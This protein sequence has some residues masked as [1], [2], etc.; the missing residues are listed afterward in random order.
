VPG[1]GTTGRPKTLV[2]AR[3]ADHEVREKTS[4]RKRLRHPV[5]GELELRFE[6]LNPADEPDHRLLAYTA[7]PGSPSAERLAVLASWTADGA[8][9]SQEE[10]AAAN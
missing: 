8:D 2:R 6:R 9:T 3:W 1:I 4:G 5:V 7:E 10:R